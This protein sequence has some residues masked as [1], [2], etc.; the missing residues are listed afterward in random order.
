MT[1]MGTLT[2]KR[3]PLGNKPPKHL[4]SKTLNSSFQ[5]RISPCGAQSTSPARGTEKL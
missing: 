3:L 4:E 2:H 1:E 5:Q